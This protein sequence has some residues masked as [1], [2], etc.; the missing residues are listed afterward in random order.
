MNGGFIA[1]LLNHHHHRFALKTLSRSTFIVF[2]AIWRAK[3]EFNLAE[4]FFHS[5]DCV[6]LF[7]TVM[8]IEALIAFLWVFLN[9][10]L[11]IERTLRKRKRTKLSLMSSQI[12]NDSICC[13]TFE[14]KSCEE[15]KMKLDFSI[16]NHLIPFSRSH[17]DRCC[18]HTFSRVSICIENRLFYDTIKKSRK[19]DSNKHVYCLLQRRSVYYRSRSLY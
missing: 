8:S 18:L 5:T 2:V 4:F 9:K 7:R 11:Q 16:F 10:L 17:S 13:G 12:L 3:N 15:I 1:L 6:Y 19:R 14:V